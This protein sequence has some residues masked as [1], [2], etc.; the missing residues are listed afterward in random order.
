[1][2]GEVNIAANPS[3]DAPARR[4]RPAGGFVN[5]RSSA[6]LVSGGGVG[7]FGRLFGASSRSRSEQLRERK[8]NR[9]QSLVGGLESVASR[10]AS[11]PAIGGRRGALSPPQLQLGSRAEASS[12]VQRLRD[13]QQSFRSARQQRRGGGRCTSRA[14]LTAIP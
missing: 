12:T 7:G 6:P 2:A 14:L 11:A 4:S 10:I 5:E 3:G 1:M 8:L 9:L 13:F